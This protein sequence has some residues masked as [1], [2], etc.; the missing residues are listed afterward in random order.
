M[1][2]RIIYTTDEGGVAVIVPSPDCDLTIEEI[3]AKDV[4]QGVAFDIVDVSAIP[5]DRSFRN[6]WEKQGSDIGHNM[7]KAK[8]IA[9]ERRRAAREAEF[10]PL[11]DIIAKQIPGKDAQAAEA[12]RQ[13][14]RDKYAAIQLQIDA[15][16]T[17][18]EIKAAMA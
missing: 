5:A 15:A 14:I 16:T 1:N 4:P 8:L 7:D 9:H 6:A 2:Q 13:F 10:A 11:D 18:D 3:A 17:I 12:A